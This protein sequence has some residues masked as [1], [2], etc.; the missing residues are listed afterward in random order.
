[1]VKQNGVG[2]LLIAVATTMAI[3]ALGCDVRH[4]SNDST[5][6]RADADVSISLE[7]RVIDGSRDSSN[8]Y[9]YV[10]QVNDN[11]TGTVISSAHVITAAH[12]FCRHTWD[13][14]GNCY[15]SSADCDESAAV[16]T[17]SS[18]VGLAE[19]FETNVIVHPEFRMEYR[20]DDC[21]GLTASRVNADIAI[22]TLIPGES[23]FPFPELD[24]LPQLPDDS[25]PI[26]GAGRVV[27]FGRNTCEGYLDEGRYY[28]SLDY[29]RIGGFLVSWN[30]L[31]I[32][33][34]TW[35]GDSGGPLLISSDDGVLR[36]GGVL[37]MS[38]T[39]YP[40]DWVLEYAHFS[41]T[42]IYSEWLEIVLSTARD[43]CHRECSCDDID[44]DGHY[45]ADCVDL[46]CYPRDDCDDINSEMN[47]DEEERCGNRQDDN[48]DGTVD[49]W[50]CDCDDR[51]S[52]G[53]YPEDCSDVDCPRRSDCDNHDASVHPGATEECNGIDDDC[54]DT[55]DEG[56]CTCTDNDR[57]GYYPTGCTDSDCPHRT[58]CDDI[59]AS[60]HP[61][62]TEE[63]NGIDDDCDD[64]IDEGCCTCTDNDDDGYYPTTCSDTN[65]SP[66]TD[67]NDSNDIVH[68]GAVEI[69]EN[70]LDDDC[71]RG[72]EPC[73]CIPD[74]TGVECGSDGCDGTCLPGCAAGTEFCD[75]WLCIPCEGL[76]ATDDDA[77]G[78]TEYDGDCDDSHDAIYPGAP[79]ICSAI[80][81]KDCDSELEEPG[82]CLADFNLTIT[83]PTFG[84]P[85]SGTFEIAATHLMPAA[86]RCRWD[87]LWA[88]A[89]FISGGT[90]E[91]T[92]VMF[93]SFGSCTS[94]PAD[95]STLTQPRYTLRV[96]LDPVTEDG[97]ALAV[98][99]WDETTI[100][101]E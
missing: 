16:W 19:R 88:G 44:H 42:D 59:R 98:P 69:C 28:A 54:D 71:V 61:G 100:R 11:C 29:N 91:Y 34:M 6:T 93:C 7:D 92:V 89:E 52:D 73:P 90:T 43:D 86:T 75:A 95:A 97:Y 31:T 58:D 77:D 99:V 4:S 96:T 81:D 76:C 13:D 70:G 38:T 84:T 41:R 18:G 12:C 50:C 33:A 47:P 48:C 62:A 72:D 26:S 83:S 39:C 17:W 85:V 9:S 67:C 53:Y 46:E 64:T 1:M 56:C 82:I 23:C 25:L 40:L 66:R 87:S 78:F 30:H 63:C 57:D 24:S 68:P 101:V 10:V 49:E 5:E 27:G 79:E 51:D 37:S 3:L 36:V 80:I 8:R 94:F 22:L 45:S 15:R 60:V 20:D 21:S 65:C 32:G 14:E 74:C 55:I 35:K 2:L